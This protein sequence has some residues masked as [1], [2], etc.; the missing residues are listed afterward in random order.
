M[1]GITSPWL[2]HPSRVFMFLSGVLIVCDVELLKTAI[3][4]CI[5]TMTS[6]C[7]Q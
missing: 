1:L 3:N 7:N 5:V 6:Y 2:Q 4:G